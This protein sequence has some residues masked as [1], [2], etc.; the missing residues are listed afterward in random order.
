MIDTIVIARG[1]LLWFSREPVD[2]S[3]QSAFSYIEDAG[4]V[5][6]NGLIVWSGDWAEMPD[7]FR[8]IDY[9]D[10]RPHLILPGFVDC[11]LHFPQSQVVAS[12]AGSLLEWLNNYTFIEEQ[13]YG[14]AD[15]A[16]L[17]A[18]RFLDQLIRHG[19]TTAVAFCSVHKAS[20]DALLG[21]AER[22]SMRIVAGKVM[23]DR[24]APE[25]LLDNAQMSYDDTKDL[26]EHWTGKGRAEVA[27]TPRFALTST[28]AQLEAAGALV[29]EYP[30]A[31]MQTHLSENHAEIKAV[32][33]LFPSA[34]D[35]TDVYSRYGL[36]SDRSLMGHA[37]H[38]S[39]RE[40]G[41]LAETGAVSVF[42]PTSNLFLGSGFF[43]LKATE[44]AGQRHAIATDI[45]GGTSW[46]MLRTLDE[47][48]K[49]HNCQGTRYNPLRSFYQATLGNALAIGMADKIGTLEAGTEADFIVLDAAATDAMALRSETV[50][51]LSEE[52]FLLQ[53]MG[54]DRAVKSTYVNGCAV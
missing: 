45:G 15:F 38:L 37:I 5:A 35:Y 42:C 54:D 29:Q 14:D 28:E 7:Q 18:A 9:V 8:N 13:K 6:K 39:D 32:S 25:A 16:T 36:L 3:D 19:T 2:E 44:K 4:L 27:I 51:T 22:R 49:I 43:D 48:Y 47:G 40:R 20:C 23:M 41:A 31:L 21:E 11:H 52:L 33:E 30:E 24:N 10:H 12:Y 50:Q 17:M 26:I 1:R 53:T 34:K 46:S